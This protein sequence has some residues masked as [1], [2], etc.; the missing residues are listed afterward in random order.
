MAAAG[1]ADEEGA[2]GAPSFFDRFDKVD[3]D[4]W[5]KPS[6]ARSQLLASNHFRIEGS[7]Q[8]S[9]DFEKR[10][11]SF[12]SCDRAR[13]RRFGTILRTQEIG[14]TCIEIAPLSHHWIW[15][16]IW[17]SLERGD[18]PPLCPKGFQNGE[19]GFK[20]Q[21]AGNSRN[22]VIRALP[23]RKKPAEVG[24]AITCDCLNG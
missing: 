7:F 14:E 5:P 18:P 19:N 13:V 1:R 11:L 12:L 20:G 15:K 23:C 2:T 10:V 21:M 17:K 8:F 9:Q 6:D 4:L 16:W 22:D 3:H 24:R